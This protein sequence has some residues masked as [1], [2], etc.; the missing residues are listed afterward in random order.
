[1]DWIDLAQDTY[2]WRAVVNNVLNLQVPK[3]AGN[4]S[5]SRGTVSFPERNLLHGV[6]WLI[7]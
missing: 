2:R 6:S 3:S 1:M 7:V 5:T 4:F